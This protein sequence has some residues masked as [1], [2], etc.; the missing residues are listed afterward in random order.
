MNSRPDVEHMLTEER[1]EV[2]SPRSGSGLPLHD[3]HCR[4]CSRCRQWIREAGSLEHP[5]V[6]DA[7]P[8]PAGPPMEGFGKFAQ[9][10]VDKLNESA[11][12]PSAAEQE[13]ARLR[14]ERPWCGLERSCAYRNGCSR[15]QDLRHDGWHEA[16]VEVPP[17]NLD[18]DAVLR[19]LAVVEEH[20]ALGPETRAIC[21]AAR[22]WVQQRNLVERCHVYGCSNPAAACLCEP[23]HTALANSRPPSASSSP[24]ARADDAT[25]P[26][27][28]RERSPEPIDVIEGWNLGFH[29]GNVVKY[30]ARAPHKGNQVGDLRK[31]RWYLDRAIARLEPEAS[32]G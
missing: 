11:E 21:D 32:R 31:A 28:Y 9:Q 16:P 1:C 4:R 29:E 12:Q 7:C 13:Q 27:H 17:P 18:P 6:D 23:C 20:A 3:G 26:S 15:H 5:T 24:T 30:V 25:N 22:A 8:G 14:A 10:V 19:A 2:G